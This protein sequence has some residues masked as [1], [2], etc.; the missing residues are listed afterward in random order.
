MIGACYAQTFPIRAA[1]IISGEII[2]PQALERINRMKMMMQQG[3]GM[4]QGPM[5]GQ[6]QM[7]EI[8]GIQMV[9]GRVTFL[10]EGADQPVKVRVNVTITPG[11]KGKRL[12]GIDVHT[13]GISSGSENV[14]EVCGSI[15]PLW[16][17]RN[18]NTGSLINRNIGDLANVVDRDGTIMSDLI[19]P[20]MKLYGTET[21]IGRAIVMYERA[22][23]EVRGNMPASNMGPRIA[24]GNIVYTN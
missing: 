7:E 9:F 4:M 5:G 13:F 8:Q 23:N 12:R 1:A 10:Q 21:V 20:D 14:G 22:D 18:V 24:C 11:E 3:Q 6:G 19:V 15:G 16:N 17:P 2:S